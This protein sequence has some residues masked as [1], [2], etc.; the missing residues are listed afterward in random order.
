MKDKYE[1]YEVMTRI[2][3]TIDEDSYNVRI[4]RDVSVMDD[5]FIRFVQEGPDG[6]THL[7][8]FDEKDLLRALDIL[9]IA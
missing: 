9:G 2:E 3:G 1:T 6:E 4:E 5:T 8:S 7:V